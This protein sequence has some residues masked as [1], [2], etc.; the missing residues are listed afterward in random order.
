MAVVHGMGSTFIRVRRRL[1]NLSKYAVHVSFQDL[2]VGINGDDDG[3]KL[4]P[5]LVVTDDSNRLDTMALDQE[6]N[7]I[8]GIAVMEEVI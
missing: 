6:V 1:I 8:F 5:T 4:Q 2:L 7:C 3:A